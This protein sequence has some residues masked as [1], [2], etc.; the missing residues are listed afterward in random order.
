MCHCPVI[1]METRHSKPISLLVVVDSLGELRG[2]EHAAA[3]VRQLT[4]VGW[5]FRKCSAPRPLLHRAS[6]FVPPLGWAN[7]LKPSAFVSDPEGSGRERCVEASP[8]ESGGCSVFCHTTI[9][10]CAARGVQH[11]VAVHLSQK[12][13]ASPST[14]SPR[15]VSSPI[16][17][18]L[19]ARLVRQSNITTTQPAN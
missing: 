15:C 1:E 17:P 13:H 6:V 14:A 10:L 11:G 7:L 16:F 2:E 4:T 9:L 18:S 8:L 3:E 19:P 12:S 5:F